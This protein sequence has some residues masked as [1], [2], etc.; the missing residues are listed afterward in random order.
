MYDISWNE[1][2]TLAM[3]LVKKIECSDKTYDAVVCIS[4]G[5]LLLGRLI[6]AILKI[7]LGIIS[8][9]MVDNKYV[10]DD[11]ISCVYEIEGN[12]LLVDD[13]LEDTVSL[14]IKKLK[15]NYKK[16]D[17]I[18]LACVFYKSKNKFKPNYYINKITHKL[19][20]IYPYQEGALKETYK[21]MKG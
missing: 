1:F 18:L 5:G 12:V 11:Y 3:D 17:E 16:I 9:K 7:P 6:S 15:K 20:I 10:V 2:E 13:I 21:F 4:R 8:A 14:I 19:D